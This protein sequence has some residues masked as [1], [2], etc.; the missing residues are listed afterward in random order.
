MV[1]VLREAGLSVHI[2]KDDH[3]P[4][5]VHVEGDGVAKINLDGPGDRPAFVWAKGMNHAEKRRALEVVVRNRA[6][7]R[8]R[9]EEI[10][11]V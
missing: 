10:H 11:G 4:A 5:H 6:A 9:W 7:L 8:Q 3:P 1:T 2:Y